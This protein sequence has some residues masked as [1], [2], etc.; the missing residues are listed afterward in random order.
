ME[1][2]QKKEKEKE[3]VLQ[4]YKELTQVCSEGHTVT[5]MRQ[6]S[7]LYNLIGFSSYIVRRIRHSAPFFLQ[8][9]LEFR[10][11]SSCTHNYITYHRLR[12]CCCEE[13]KTCYRHMKLR[14]AVGSS[15]CLYR[16]QG[17]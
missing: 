6:M 3:N 7:F 9:I 5:H 11:I 14:W 15:T 10:P 2:K 12:L 13:V 1:K 16:C 4:H 8:C 17:S